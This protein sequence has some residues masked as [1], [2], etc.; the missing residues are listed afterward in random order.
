MKEFRLGILFVHGIG[1][2]P[3]RDTLVRWGD[4]LLKV[5][6]HAMAEEPGQT[7]AIVGRAKAGDSSGDNPAEVVVEFHG[8]DRDQNENWLLTEGWWAE[9]FPAPT[10]SELVSWSFRAVPWSIAV[11]IAQRY[12]QTGSQVSKGARVRAVAIAIVKLLLTMMFTPLLL[13]LLASTLVLGLLP[14][15][16]LRSLILTTQTKLVGTVGDSFA[17]VESPLRAALIR[18]RI[19]EG[20]ERLKSRCERTVIV[21]HSQGAAATLDALGGILDYDELGEG[22]VRTPSVPV[23][24][25]LVTFGSGVNQLV[26]L[27]ALAAGRSERNTATYAASVAV[28]ATLG[29]VALLVLLF[30]S[31]RSGGTRI[32][33]LGGAFIFLSAYG[34]VSAL[35]L[36]I[37]SQ[38]LDK[39]TAWGVMDARHKRLELSGSIV[40]VAA[41]L[42]AVY[43]LLRPSEDLPIVPAMFLI[44]M[45]LSLG[46]ALRLILSPITRTAVTR[47]VQHPPG[48][49]R[50]I[51]MYASADPVPYGPTRIKET[52]A[53]VT[54]VQVWNRGAFLSDHTTYWDNLD[55]FVLRVARM[56]A[57]TA[58][59]SWQGKLPPAT[60]TAWLDRRAEWRVGLLWWTRFG[61][62]M[63]WGLIWLLLWARH[64]VHVTIWAPTVERLVIT[65]LVMLAALI[66]GALLRWPWSVWVRAEQ[67]AVLAHKTPSVL[68]W[69]PF[70]GLGVV[71]SLLGALAFALLGYDF[72][73][74][75][76]LTDPQSG[77]H[78]FMLVVGTGVWITVIVYWLLPGPQP[79]SIEGENIGPALPQRTSSQ[80]SL[81]PRPSA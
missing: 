58:E 6:C 24:D 56:C 64:G 1:T 68:T 20:L 70:C 32:N 51:D 77:L 27:K 28:M 72:Q 52:P 12:W 19:L 3:A 81:P 39:F 80:A 59:S 45:L 50:W 65:A 10:Y 5:I 41:V 2:Q 73:V 15:P 18:G 36:W 76:L 17:F 47:R 49:S 79:P 57:E 30:V 78:A 42:A 21:A 31:I 54:S 13:I 44:I 34:G 37:A 26:S 63:L 43:Y 29:I 61:N 7:I 33:Y 74:S 16:Q 48:L 35:A 69:L 66:A 46:G 25:V 9:S 23:P 55:G 60:Q 11:H 71:I 75:T 40:I 8:S 22:L 14:I 53:E 4:V 67:E 62:W 38:I